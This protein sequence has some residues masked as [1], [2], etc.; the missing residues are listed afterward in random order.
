M[1]RCIKASTADSVDVETLESRVLANLDHDMILND[2]LEDY[3]PEDEKI[4]I[5]QWLWDTYELADLYK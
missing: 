4:K 3:L 5:L 2:I 1:K